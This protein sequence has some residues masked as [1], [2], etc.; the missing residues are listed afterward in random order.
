MTSSTK[1]RTALY[2]LFDQQGQLLYAG[3]AYTPEQRWLQHAVDK[4][5]W[6]LVA[7]RV[8]EWHPDRAEAEAAE[9]KAIREEAP[10]YNATDTN[11]SKT[12]D[13]FPISSVTTQSEALARLSDVLNKVQFRGEAVSITRRSKR[14]GVL[15]PPD[16]YDM[17]VA[18]IAE[19]K[20]FRRRLA[21]DGDL[22]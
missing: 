20:E 15:V 3:I 18:A 22:S 7:R 13:H 19:N 11:A 14:S 12:T 5:W 10:L 17:A 16:W 8:V 9:R 1:R 21:E 2:R 4:P 6:K